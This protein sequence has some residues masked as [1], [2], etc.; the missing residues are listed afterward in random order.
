[1]QSQ[2][3]S[4]KAISVRKNRCLVC[5]QGSQ[6]KSLLFSMMMLPGIFCTY[7]Y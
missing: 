6:E 1:L 4:T 7:P 2:S 3:R 5:H